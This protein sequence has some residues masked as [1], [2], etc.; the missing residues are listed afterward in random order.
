[1]SPRAQSDDEL[2]LAGLRKA[3]REGKTGA[4]NDLAREIA[5]RN[6]VTSPTPTEQRRIANEA[7]KQATSRSRATHV[8]DDPPE[9]AQTDFELMAELTATNHACDIEDATPGARARANA[10]AVQ[11]LRSRGGSA[12]PAELCAAGGVPGWTSHD[13]CIV[14]LNR[15]QLDGLANA[16]YVN[17]PASSERRFTL[18]GA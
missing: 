9:P 8:L 5:R 12:T 13:A 6:R 4:A 14:R 2:V 10:E 17:F 7:K 3:V 16:E 18:S 15:M 11:V 1:M